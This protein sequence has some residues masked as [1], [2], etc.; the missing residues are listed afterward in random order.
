MSKRTKNLVLVI[1]LLQILIV[2]GL[3]ALPAVVRAIPG[4]YR[5]ALSERNRSLSELAEGVIDRV[6]PVATALPAPEQVG[7]AQEVDFSHLLLSEPTASLVPP[8]PTMA[9]TPT[10]TNA[11][12]QGDP[13]ESATQVPTIAPTNTPTPAA[14]ATPEPLP[15]TVRLEGI[16]VIKQTFNNCGPANLTQ[17]LNFK[18]HDITQADVASY[19]KPSA[20]DRNVSPWQIADYVNERT[21]LIASAHSGGSLE[22]LKRF[23]AAGHPVVVEKGYEL[24]SSGWWGHYLTVFGYDDSV[25]EF[26]VQDSYLGPWDGSGSVISYEEMEFYW[27]QFNYTFYLVYQPQEEATIHAILGSEMQQEFTMWSNAAARADLER[28]DDPEDAFAWFNLG[29]SLTRMGQ[30]TGNADYYLG[31]VQAFDQARAIGLPP[32]MLWYQFRPYMAYWKSGRLDD[33]IALADATLET[34]G[35]RNVEETYWYK[36]HA[37]LSQGDLSGARTAYQAALAVNSN[38]YPAQISLDSLDG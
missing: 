1:A 24:P 33:V 21:P 4:R 18:Q 13:D 23:I 2:A 11:V 28:Q 3:F 35:G 22:M 17:V 16:G 31:G 20:E 5:V 29:T 38:F 32:R 7:S 12:V 19:L 27:Q 34:Q 9:A 15:E 36:G 37:L 10:A 8:T 6:A 14:T 30:L 25:A 26:N